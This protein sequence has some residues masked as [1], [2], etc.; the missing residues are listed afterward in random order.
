MSTSVSLA[1]RLRRQA[2]ELYATAIQR[3]FRNSRLK[4]AACTIQRSIRG[5]FA[6]RRLKSLKLTTFPGRKCFACNELGDQRCSRCKTTQFC[7]K[8]CQSEAWPLHKWT[9]SPNVDVR[10]AS[11]GGKGLF[12]KRDFDVGE[13]LIREK[14]LVVTTRLFPASSLAAA[15]YMAELV[16]E[17]AFSE[18]A[19]AN[20]RVA[21][22]LH[23]WRSPSNPTAG[24][25]AKTNG[26]PLGCTTN[27]ERVAN[28]GIF[29]LA[30]RL[31]HSCQPNARYTWRPDIKRELV[32]A[33]RP[34]ECG[35]EITV[36]YIGRYLPRNER[37]ARCTEE[38]G[39]SCTCSLC[40]SPSQESDE[41]M[42]QMQDLIDRIPLVF[43]TQGPTAPLRM[44]E[45]VLQLLREQDLNTPVDRGTIHYDA[46]QM[47]RAL[48]D[49]PKMRYH[50]HQATQCAIQSD[51]PDS[52]LVEKYRELSA[53]HSL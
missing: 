33:M 28:S 44:A 10:P 4:S 40:A 38:F 43:G 36:C 53:R 24:G 25:I 52:P 42:T 1:N 27:G 12:A 22:S 13:E 26:I 51:G 34:I 30:C 18:L 8:K 48:S 21:E 19:P 3:A 29:A 39:F 7:S 23:D 15:E 47:A 50:L 46:F 49:R 32:F 37:Q 14:P 11:T 5:C 41:R 16:A 6:R 9:C 31:N 17:K 35:E 45:R 20:K 2:D